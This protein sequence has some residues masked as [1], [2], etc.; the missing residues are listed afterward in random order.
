M[1]VL[2]LGATSQISAFCF[3]FTGAC[4]AATYTCSMGMSSYDLMR[5]CD[6]LEEA[7]CAY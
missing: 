6:E 5:Y 4:G 3:H 2:L 7:M 1:T